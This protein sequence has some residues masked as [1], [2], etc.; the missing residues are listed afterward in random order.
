LKKNPLRRLEGLGQ[1]V[2]LDYIGRSF[3]TS[4][5]LRNM[6]R[7]DGVSGMTSNSQIFEKAIAES[8]EYDDDIRAMSKKGMAAIDIYGALSVR[9]IQTAA[10]EFMP[11]YE[12]TKAIDGYVSLEADPHLTHDAGG[13]IKEAR[14]LWTAVGRPNIMIKIPSTK[15]AVPAIKQLTSEGINI[16]ATLLLSVERYGEVA[17]A[18]ISGLEEGLAAGRDI[19]RTASVSSFFLSRIDGYVDPVLEKITAGGGD[20]A[21]AAMQLLGQ[22][23]IAGAK[24]AYRL[25]KLLFNRERFEAF[26]DRGARPQRLLWDSTGTKNPGYSDIKYVEALV[27]PNTVNTVPVETLNAYR[28]HGDPKLSLEMETGCAGWVLEQLSTFGVNMDQVAVHLEREG[29]DGFKASF[30]KMMD[31]LSKKMGVKN[32]AC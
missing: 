9:D 26:S 22:S 7:D 24:M 11:V 28:N 30:D 2:W 17:G 27:G 32:S 21:E 5:R 16:N 20:G 3:I 18:Y 4:G 23:A 13:T 15:E 10:D 14:R 29:I 19:S 8:G 25:Y 6:I 31:M 1:S 12:R